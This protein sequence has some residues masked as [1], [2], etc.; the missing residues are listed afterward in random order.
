M[1]TGN[2]SINKRS[3]GTGRAPRGFHNLTL[4]KST[5]NSKGRVG[6]RGGVGHPGPDPRMRGT[7]QSLWVG[8]VSPPGVTS[9]MLGTGMSRTLMFQRKGSLY[10]AVGGDKA[11]AAWATTSPHVSGP[12]WGTL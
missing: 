1:K 7:P 2:F 8:G 5:N 10:L 9:H 6:A 3:W 11:E 12:V 4:F